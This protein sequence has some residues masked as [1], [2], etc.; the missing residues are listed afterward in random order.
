MLV[1]LSL[2]LIFFAS[3]VLGFM[4]KMYVTRSN[5]KIAEQKVLELTQEKEKLSSDITK[6][7]TDKGVEESIR[8]KFGLAKEGEGQIVILEDKNTTE[9]QKE[10]TSWFFGWFSALFK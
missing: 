2:L 6:L 3:Q 7:Q 4:G 10:E 8:D 5:R 9:V 1:S